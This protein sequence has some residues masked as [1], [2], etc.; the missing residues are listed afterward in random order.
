[1][2]KYQSVAVCWMIDFVDST[3]N[4]RETRVAPDR[5]PGMCLVRAHLLGGLRSTQI[6]ADPKHTQKTQSLII[7]IREITKEFLFLNRISIDFSSIDPP[8][9]SG[10]T[11]DRCLVFLQTF[12]L[13]FSLSKRQPKIWTLLMIRA[14]K[15]NVNQ[16]SFWGYVYIQLSKACSVFSDWSRTF[17]I[18]LQQSNSNGWFT[19]PLFLSKQRYW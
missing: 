6:A 17:T 14:T 12:S 3:N 8:A 7:S 19:S 10:H 5:F 13:H 1:M 11:V 18:T 2:V 16:I 9:S 4:Y 15:L